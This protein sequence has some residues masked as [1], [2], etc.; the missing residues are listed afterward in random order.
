MNYT[1][2]I[3]T[4]IIKARQKKLLALLDSKCQ[5]SVQ[6]ESLVN[7]AEKLYAQTSPDGREIIRQNMKYKNILHKYCSKILIIL[8]LGI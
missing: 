3:F 6:Y 4:I 5:Q 1:Y 7:M 2:F 8:I